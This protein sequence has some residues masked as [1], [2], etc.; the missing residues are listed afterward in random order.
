M[1]K[2]LLIVILLLA[3][4][5]VH[6]QNQY[7]L[8]NEAFWKTIVIDS[9][10]NVPA[11]YDACIAMA[12]SCLPA[13]GN[14][15]FISQRHNENG[16]LYYFIYSVGNVWHVLPERTL[17]DA[18]RLVGINDKDWVVYTEGMGKIFTIDVDRGLKMAEQYGVNV[19]MIDYPSIRT[20]YGS[21]K[22]YQ[23]A[24]RSSRAAYRDFLPVL[25]SVKNLAQQKML[26][27]NHLSLFFHSMGNNVVRDMVLRHRLDPLND[28]VWVNNLILNAPCVQQRRHRKWLD[29]IHFAQRIFVHYNPGDNTLKW[30]RLL[31]FKKQL[32][33][34]L[35]RPL[36]S[37]AT[38]I[39]FNMLC[40]ENHSNFLTF[41][42]IILPEA[43]A[44]YSLLF[45][46][47]DIPVRDTTRYRPSLYRGIGYDILP[48]SATII[49]IGSAR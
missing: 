26:G 18:I 16:V 47:A 14:V 30:A 24:K 25:D 32:G 31:S 11:H 42:S 34:R 5:N 8:N 33:D 35:R 10:N 7:D 4:M 2:R 23:F 37:H 29:K 36:S 21:Y 44:H 41:Y 40:G 48:R 13:P 46:G 9:N 6:A 19:L 28:T 3:A 39:N 22:N 38:Y 17:S 20:D 15:R 43:E 1:S 45:H 27:F 12:S 49:K